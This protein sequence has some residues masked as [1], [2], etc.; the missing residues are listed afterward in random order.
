MKCY[1]H[2]DTDAVAA[3]TNCGK[4]ICQSCSV[5]VSGKLI[6]Q[7]CLS[8]GAATSYR[9]QSI[10]PAKTT[11]TLAIVSLVLGIMGLCG[12][13]LFSIPAWITGHMALKQFTENP[14]QEGQ[15]MAKAGRILGIVGT[16]LW[17]L[18]I[19]CYVGILVITLISASSSSYNYI[20][21]FN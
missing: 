4:A 15:G 11:N 20:A 9:S 6:C 14:E 1:Y 10:Q 12:S 21:I 5:N 2:P 16:V 13:F 7:T 8:S 3:C 17:I 18:F 19:V